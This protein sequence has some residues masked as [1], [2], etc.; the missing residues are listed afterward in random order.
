M[1]V[2]VKECGKSRG[3]RLLKE[4]IKSMEIVLKDVFD[5]AVLNGIIYFMY[6]YGSGN[7]IK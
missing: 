6:C 3:I 7:L 5:V 2:Q 1:Q 4:L